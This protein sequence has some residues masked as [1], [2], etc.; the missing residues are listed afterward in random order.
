MAVI[1]GTR[2]FET[3]IDI[4]ADAR[5]E[6]VDMLNQQ[7]ADVIT[8]HSQTKQAHWNVK[9]ER[10][11]QLHGLYDELA[12]DIFGYIDDTAER[13]TALGGTALGTTE[14]AA[15]TTA[16]PAYPLE[17]ISGE[18]TLKLL[19]ERFSM[20]VGSVRRRIARASELD[21]PTTE[22]LLTEMTRV[23]DEK[24]YFLE[25]HLQG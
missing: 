24:L 10:F 20:T 11:F 12:N 7:L 21:D 9:G 13:V 14:L 2:M 5:H 23:L 4:H 3:N 19:I 25:S 8:L 18:D 16:L 22:D 17:K 1:T 6:L 15:N